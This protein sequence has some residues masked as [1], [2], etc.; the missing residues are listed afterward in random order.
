MTPMMGWLSTRGSGAGLEFTTRGLGI[1]WMVDE[2]MQITQNV[3]Y[4]ITKMPSDSKPLNFVNQT[5]NG[6]D[7]SRI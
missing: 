2:V 6:M 7:I 1:L 4:L 3:L 5:K